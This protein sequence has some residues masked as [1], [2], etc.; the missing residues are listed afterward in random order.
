MRGWGGEG[1]ERGLEGGEEVGQGRREAKYPQSTLQVI[2]IAKQ[3]FAGIK[4]HIFQNFYLNAKITSLC[5][6]L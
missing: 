6:T 2:K 5:L 1:R 4:L 3:Q